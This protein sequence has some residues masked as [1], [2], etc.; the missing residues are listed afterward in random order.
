M[1]LASFKCLFNKQIFLFLLV[2]LCLESALAGNPIRKGLPEYG[3]RDCHVYVEKGRYYMVGT[4]IAPPG[5]D[6]EGISLYE[7]KDMKKW[8]KTRVLRVLSL[9]FLKKKFKRRV[10]NGGDRQT[11]KYCVR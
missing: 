1:N 5:E 9:E 7:S 11:Y 8:K 3:I 10:K 4:E 2:C 6:K